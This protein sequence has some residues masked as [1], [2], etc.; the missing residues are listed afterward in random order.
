MANPVAV[1]THVPH[2]TLNHAVSS[3]CTRT[4]N[5]MIIVSDDL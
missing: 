4:A 2:L 3:P 5:M 1:H